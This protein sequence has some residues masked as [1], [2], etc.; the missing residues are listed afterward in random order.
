MAKTEKRAGNGN[1]GEANKPVHTVGPFNS[2][3]SLIEASVWENEV[4]EGDEARLVFNVTVQRSYNDG[5]EWKRTK[6]FRP[7][8]LPHLIEV[9]RLAYLWCQEQANKRGDP[10][11]VTA[12]SHP[13]PVLRRRERPQRR[14]GAFLAALPFFGTPC[15]AEW[16]GMESHVAPAAVGRR[17]VR[18]VFEHV[19]R[20]LTQAVASADVAQLH[21]RVTG[22]GEVLEGDNVGSAFA[23]GGE[24]S[25][26]Q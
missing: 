5:E 8:D 12:Q 24:G 4:G 9:T 14:L 22:A 15:R 2:G 11:S 23:G 3:G 7:Q 6:S 17:N 20:R 21:A 16:L 19:G 26:P 25:H 18:S 13:L 10:G 1:G